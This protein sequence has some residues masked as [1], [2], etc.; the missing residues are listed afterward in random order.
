MTRSPDVAR[1]ATALAHLSAPFRMSRGLYLT[2]AV[3]ALAVIC[4]EAGSSFLLSFLVIFALLKLAKKPSPGKPP[5]DDVPQIGHSLSSLVNV[6]LGLLNFVSRI[7]TWQNWLESLSMLVLLIT[8]L[9]ALLFLSAHHV[10]AALLAVIIAIAFLPRS[11]KT[12]PKA[13]LPPIPA[14]RAR[15]GTWAAAAPTEPDEDSD[16]SATWEPIT[17]PSRGRSIELSEVCHV[18]HRAFSLLTR[19]RYC[20][21]CGFVFCRTCCARRVPAL[22]PAP[23][24]SDLSLGPLVH[25]CD[26]CL[27]K[28]QA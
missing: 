12:V 26:A 17:G 10:A 25:V 8:S 14:S 5:A 15:V 13:L 4:V 21:D 19:K 24:A 1:V 16:D 6:A 18:C 22:S 28:R 27:A 7:L 3:F 20:S 11:S 9:T 2:V 23:G